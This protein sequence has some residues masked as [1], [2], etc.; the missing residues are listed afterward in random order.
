MLVIPD[1]PKDFYSPARMTI[2]IKGKRVQVEIRP[3]DTDAADKCREQATRREAVKHP[4][5]GEVV[6]ANYV[7]RTA[8]FE[9]MMDHCIA[10][11]SGAGSAKDKPWPVDRQHKVLLAAI[12]PDLGEQPVY[13][14]VLDAALKLAEDLIARQR[15]QI[16][17]DEK[18]F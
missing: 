12:A 18:N 16:E 8:L 13:R 17:D 3:Y 5:T 4:E 14:Q 9:E 15:K 1:K 11:F 2:S 10:G 7:D 6:L